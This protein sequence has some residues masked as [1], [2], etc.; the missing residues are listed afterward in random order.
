MMV[1]ELANPT[2]I[3]EQSSGFDLLQN[4]VLKFPFT[5][6]VNNKKQ[7]KVAPRLIYLQS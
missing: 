2:D 5:C 3:P 6:Y 1:I 4:L 7:E